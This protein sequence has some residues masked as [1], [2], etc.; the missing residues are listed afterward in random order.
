MFWARF[1][2]LEA[3]GLDGAVLADVLSPIRSTSAELLPPDLDR[4]HLVVAGSNFFFSI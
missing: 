2:R 1:C 3:S 4:K